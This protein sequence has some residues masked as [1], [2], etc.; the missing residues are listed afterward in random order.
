MKI[1]IT[2][3]SG[4]I[5]KSLYKTLCLGNEVYGIDKVFSDGFD[6][7]IAID[8]LKPERVETLLKEKGI[9]HMDVIIHCASILA[10]SDNHEDLDLLYK[11]LKIAESVITITK[12]LCPKKLINFSTIG[13]YSAKDGNYTEES[14]IKPSENY[15]ALYDLSKFCSEELFSFMLRDTLTDVVNM[16]VSQ[17]IGSG[18]RK[19]RIYAIMLDELKRTNKISVWGNGERISAFISIEYLINTIKSIIFK[20][21][22]EGT[23]N[24]GEK[25]MSYH[26]LAKDIIREFGNSES[27]IILMDKGKKSRNYIDFTKINQALIK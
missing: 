14:S 23:F 27:E 21:G 22:L 2:G 17:T 9:P 24:I 19:D 16:R 7:F 3:C 12:I 10:T 5:G 26:Q 4:F 20:E 18:M 1:L 6:H 15:E 11:N 25:N 13:V 8:L